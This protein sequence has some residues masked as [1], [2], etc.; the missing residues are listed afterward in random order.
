MFAASDY[1]LSTT[2]SC[3]DQKKLRVIAKEL[4]AAFEKDICANGIKPMQLQWISTTALPQIMNKAFLGVESPPNW[5]LLTEELMR[6]C[7]KEGDLCTEETQ[8]Q[9]AACVQIKVPG[10][11]LQLGPWVAE[12]CKKINDEVVEHWPEKKDKVIELI[13]QFQAQSTQPD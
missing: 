8:R 1:I 11:L 12:N 2:L 5:Q 7:F 13:K 10:I 6:D 9:V 3:L 4:E